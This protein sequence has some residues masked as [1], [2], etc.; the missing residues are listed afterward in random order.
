MRDSSLHN[1]GDRPRQSS[2]SLEELIACGEGKIFG[3][4]SPRLP[5]GQ[6]RMVDRIT[7]IAAVGGA[8][9]HGLIHAELDIDPSLW[10]FACH[11]PGDPVMPGCLGLDAM[12]QLIGFFLAWSGHRGLGRALGVEDVRFF[13][14][15]LPQVKRVNYHIDIKRVITRRLIMATAEGSLAADGQKIYTA[16]GL[17]VGVF[18]GANALQAAASSADA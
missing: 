3:P 13:G 14:Q 5:S 18:E 11:F 17:R 9:G 15:V 1:A 8:H 16:R 10:F 12:W 2:F 6:M 7:H 4:D